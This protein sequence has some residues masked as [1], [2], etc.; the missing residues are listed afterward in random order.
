MCNNLRLF[1]NTFP[2]VAA[3]NAP[4][5]PPPKPPPLKPPPPK[6]PPLH[7]EPVLLARGAATNAWCA[8]IAMAC[9]EPAKK[10]GLNATYGVGPTYQLGGFCMIPWNAFAQ[11][12][13]MP[14]AI[15]YGR[16]FSNVSG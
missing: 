8:S 4:P 5:P 9:I 3:Q 13:S 12:F 16:N 1:P 11:R 2:S 10:M 7:P 14:S 15:A 6:P